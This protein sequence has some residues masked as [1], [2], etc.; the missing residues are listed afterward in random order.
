MLRRRNEKNNDN[1][2]LPSKEVPIIGLPVHSRRKVPSS[3][4]TT[5]LR[6]LRLTLHRNNGPRILLPHTSDSDK[7]RTLRQKSQAIEQR[8]GARH[9]AEQA[10]SRYERGILCEYTC[11]VDGFTMLS[12]LMVDSQKLAAKDLDD[13]EQKRV[14]R[15]P[16]EHDG[17]M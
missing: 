7:I 17:V 12:V 10:E 6:T 3:S 5:S 14:K 2:S 4:C 9:W 1:G 13:W 16:G 15:L 11:R 8:R